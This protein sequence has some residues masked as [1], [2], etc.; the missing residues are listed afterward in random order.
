MSSFVDHAKIEIQSGKG[1]AGCVSFRRE[2]YIPRGGP[3][4]G[5]GGAGGCVYLKAEPNQ[6]TL[7]EYH[8]QR[9]FKADDGRPG[10]KRMRY[11]AKGKDVVI[12]VPPGTIVYDTDTNECIIDL[13]EKSQLFMVAP[14]GRGGKGNAFFATATRQAPKFAQPGEPGIYRKL[15]LELKLLADI[16]LV[17]LPNSGKST[18]ISIISEAKPKIADYPFT[19]LI[20]HLG[21]VRRG[22]NRE[23][24]VA[25]IPGIIEGAHDGKGLGDRFLRHIER[26]ALLLLLVDTSLTYDITPEKTPE[27]LL[28]E[29]RLY[30]EILPLRVRAIVAT[31]IDVPGSQDQIGK[32]E[33]IAR[34][35]DLHFLAISSATKQNIDPLLDFMER[36]YL[37]LRLVEEP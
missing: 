19:T 26:S 4:G 34:Q 1:G 15:T 22:P 7:L 18:L 9:I 21:V 36:E 23:F 10:S 8:Y 29:L 6:R 28:N 33:E 30:Q 35:L 11:G 2:K 24:V 12:P 3:D 31:K 14:G 16:G 27:I 32:L 5:D 13:K 37:R 20:P 25:D 17:G